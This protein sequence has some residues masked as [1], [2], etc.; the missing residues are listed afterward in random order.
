[1]HLAIS[2]AGVAGAK[3]TDTRIR[4]VS[5]SVVVCLI[6]DALVVTDA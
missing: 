3:C 1:M 5:S 6:E 2:K 4:N